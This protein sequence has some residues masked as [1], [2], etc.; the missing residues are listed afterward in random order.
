MGL[1]GKVSPLAVPKREMGKKDYCSKEFET[2]VVMGES[3]VA[4]GSWLARTEDRWADILARLINQC[5]ENPVKYYNKGIGANVITP[6]S[7]G[8]EASANPSALERYKEDV[9]GVHPDQFTLCYGLNDMRA[10]MDVEDFREDMQTVIGD[11]K[12]ACA[13][14]IVLT[15]VYHMTA[16]RSYAPFDKGSVNRTRIYNEAIRQLACDNDCLL[17]DV[18]EG[19]GLADWLIHP[20][21][22]HANVVGNLIIAHRVFEILAQNCSGLTSGAFAR[23]ANTDWTKGTTSARAEA[24]DQF[25]RSWE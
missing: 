9:I 5:Q 7:P 17:A 13:P 14:V 10:G 15:T 18:W 21:G 3:T 12:E 25:I 16:F 4:G 2:M 6:R 23:D 20:D 19:E 22:V 11:I 24:G 8:Y 1:K